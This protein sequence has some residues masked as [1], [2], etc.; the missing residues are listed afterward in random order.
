MYIEKNE[1][2][3][4][5][6]MKVGDGI[7]SITIPSNEYVTSEEIVENIND[8]IVNIANEMICNVKGGNLND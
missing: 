3:V 5:V 6:Q 4:T 2:F 7:V 1:Y 8:A